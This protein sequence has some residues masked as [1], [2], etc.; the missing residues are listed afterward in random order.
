MTS[1]PKSKVVDVEFDTKEFVA[2]IKSA[3]TPAEIAMI[4]REWGSSTS[5]R[6]VAVRK[7]FSNW[8][9]Q[10]VSNAVEQNPGTYLIMAGADIL[11]AM[12]PLLDRVCQ[13]AADR[14]GYAGYHSTT[15]VPVILG[16]GPQ[17]GV[18]LLVRSE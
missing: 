4:I 10:Q 2:T 15:M 6:V 12:K 8:V 16:P 11:Q 7:R 17:S 18:T 13:R 14:V 1:D 5:P 3:H 9:T